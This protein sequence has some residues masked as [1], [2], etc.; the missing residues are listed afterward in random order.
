MIRNLVDQ[1]QAR[2]KAAIIA[3]EPAFRRTL[4]D[5]SRTNQML[6][7]EVQI[8]LTDQFGL[9]LG[10]LDIIEGKVDTQTGLMQ[11]VVADIQE[12]KSRPSDNLFETLTRDQ[13]RT[14][15]ELR[16]YRKSHPGD[17]SGGNRN[18][19]FFKS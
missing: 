18:H 16:Q 3:D 11:Q 19:R 10:K 2:F 4:L 12:I 9:V 5:E 8:Y 17:L 15:T 6:V 1:A 14:R 7:Q 13:N